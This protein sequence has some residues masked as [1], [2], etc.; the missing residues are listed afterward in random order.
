MGSARIAHA[1]NPDAATPEAEVSALSNV[2]RFVLDCR[3][4]KEAAPQQSRPEDA[5]KDQDAGTYTHCT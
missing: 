2:Y 3:L 4:K 5:R 1:Q